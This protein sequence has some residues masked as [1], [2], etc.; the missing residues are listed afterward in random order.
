MQGVT[1][2]LTG[3]QLECAGKKAGE[4]GRICMMLIVNGALCGES[5]DGCGCN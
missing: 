5:K 1:F 2:R 3:W 4:S